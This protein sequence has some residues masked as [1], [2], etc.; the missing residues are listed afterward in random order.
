MNKLRSE[1]HGPYSDHVIF[2]DLQT[3]TWSDGT[4][5]I[6][7]IGHVRRCIGVVAVVHA[8]ERY[9]HI[10]IVLYYNVD[11]GAAAAVDVDDDDDD[12]DGDGDGDGGGVGD[13]HVVFG[14]IMFGTV[15]ECVPY[16]GLQ[17]AF[18]PVKS[19]P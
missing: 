7:T 17:S 1:S 19:P 9:S 15:A 2:H 3:Q 16:W 5:A 14:T 18:W 13:C 10:V 12:D 4:V 11:V 8:H 6:I